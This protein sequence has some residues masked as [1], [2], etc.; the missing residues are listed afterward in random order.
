[1]RDWDGRH[2]GPYRQVP[3]QRFPLLRD[4]LV[5]ALVGA[6][7]G[8]GLARR[9]ETGVWPAAFGLGSMLLFVYVLVL[10]LS[11]LWRPTRLGAAQI[12][13]LA[14]VCLVAAAAGLVLAL[15]VGD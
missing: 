5:L 15:L 11:Q 8:A 4:G 9:I 2:W 12:T 13:R 7:L 3:R 6:L 10:G 14:S 1:M